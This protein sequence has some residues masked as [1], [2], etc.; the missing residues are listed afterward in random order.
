MVHSNGGIINP[1]YENPLNC[2]DDIVTVGTTFV[3][4]T[5]TPILITTVNKLRVIIFKGRNKILTIGFI[6]T[7][8]IERTTV[9]MPTLSYV[10][11]IE[12]PGIVKLVRI[13]AVK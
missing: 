1:W 3:K 9:A 7:L 12:K 2:Q 4:P 6:N 8:I 10:L 13:S 11:P 5:I